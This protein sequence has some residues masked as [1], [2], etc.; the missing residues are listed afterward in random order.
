MKL[1]KHDA[2]PA[3]S[4]HPEIWVEGPCGDVGNKPPLRQKKS[5]KNPQPLGAPVGLII[6]RAVLGL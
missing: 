4:Q 5:C 2:N 3:I 1:C 6:S